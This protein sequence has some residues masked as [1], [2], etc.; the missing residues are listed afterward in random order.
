VHTELTFQHYLLGLFAVANN[1]PALGLFLAICQD[2][3]DREQRKLS[4][5]A[6]FSSFVLMTG[7]LVTGQMVLVF[8]GIS[9]SAFRIAGGLLLC[10]SGLGMLN[11]KPE[12]VTKHTVG[13]LDQLIPVAIVPISI[14]LTTGAGTMSTIVVYSDRFTNWPVTV[15]LFIAICVMTVIIYVS[16]RYST[17]LLR[18]L[19]HLGMDVLIKIMGLIT[20]AIGIQFI[21]KGIVTV[22]PA[23]AGVVS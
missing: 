11:S 15:P 16:F 20:L 6:T 18:V 19:G 17:T 7:A 10:V 4:I 12:V 5:I 14:P 9:L 3:T 8:F 21:L 2:L 13:N 23:W 1:F 22:F